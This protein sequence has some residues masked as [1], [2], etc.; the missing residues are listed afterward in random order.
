MS[1]DCPEGG[2]EPRQ[3]PTRRYDAPPRRQNHYASRA[4]CIIYLM[5]L[6]VLI[7]VMCIRFS[8]Y[9]DKFCKFLYCVR[10][11]INLLQLYF[12]CN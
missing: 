6:L 8:Y 2:N 5:F 9:H 1:R 7:M 3:A 4:V 10:R 12:A 11:V